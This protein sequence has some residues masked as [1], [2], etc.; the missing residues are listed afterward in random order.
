MTSEGVR[1]VQSGSPWEE[2]IGFARAVAA[3]DR[4]LVAG[5]TAFRGEVLHGEG[6]PYEQAKVAFTSAVQAL[7]EFGL[8]AEAVIRTRMYLTHM[9]DVEAVGRAHKEIF[10]PV[11]PAATLLVV[12]GFVDPRIL[13]E[14]EIEA[15]RG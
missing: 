4:V 3:G 7:G 8:G 12:E 5:T 10:D 15:F 14:V 11:R 9:R 6:D 1:R 2:S 13:V